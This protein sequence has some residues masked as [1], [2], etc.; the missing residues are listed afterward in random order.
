MHIRT[1]LVALP[2]LVLAAVGVTHP[3]YLDASTA[4]HWRDMH[5]GLAFVFPLVAVAVWVLLEGSP[6]VV[7]WV[8][9]AAAFGY[10][11]L[12][13]ALD[14]IAGVG[15]GAMA[16]AQNGR[17]AVIDPLFDVGNALGTPGAWCFL[18]AAALLFG[19]I[20]WQVGWKAVPG[21]VV[22]LFGAYLFLDSHIY[23]P[24]GVVAMVCFAVGLAALSFVSPV[25]PVAPRSS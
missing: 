15:G 10:A 17:T 22:L 18:V 8:G 2:G 13:G 21:G 14:T 1:V 3:Q 16:I 11:V 5:V 24:K 4:H 7:K 23:W 9:R 19:G 20:A 12:Y 25:R 6:V